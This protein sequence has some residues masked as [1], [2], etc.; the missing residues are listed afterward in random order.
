[1]TL[2]HRFG[3]VAISLWASTAVGVWA[4]EGRS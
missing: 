2:R 1:M 4:Q 3:V